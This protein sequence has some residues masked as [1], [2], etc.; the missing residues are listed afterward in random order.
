MLTVQTAVSLLNE[1]KNFKVDI[2]FFRQADSGAYEK[3][4]QFFDE[5]E[6]SYKSRN[7]LYH[8]L[9]G[10]LVEPAENCVW[11]WSRVNL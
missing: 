7:K 3:N 5:I 9:S 6:S 4:A 11:N 10:I 1:M 2:S 8:F